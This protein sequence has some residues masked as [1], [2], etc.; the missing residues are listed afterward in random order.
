MDL[1]G[2][3]SSGMRYQH[4]L[5]TTKE[6]MRVLWWCV[7]VLTDDRGVMSQ[8]GAE[9]TGIKPTGKAASAEAKSSP[10]CDDCY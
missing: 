10:V 1:R 4:F 2:A 7:S 8:H 3:I 5:M 9:S 6:L